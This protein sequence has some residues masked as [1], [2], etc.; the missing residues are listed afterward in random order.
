M[1]PHFWSQEL[2]IV[3]PFLMARGPFLPIQQPRSITPCRWPVETLA[4]PQLAIGKVG[5]S[6]RVEQ[7]TE[8]LPPL[9]PCHWEV[10][11]ILS[12]RELCGDQ[13]VCPS[14]ILGKGHGD[15]GLSKS[16]GRLQKD[17]SVAVLERSQSG[18]KGLPLIGPERLQREDSHELY[19][20]DG[21]GF[22]QVDKLYRRVGILFLKMKRDDSRFASQF[23]ALGT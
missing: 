5:L 8:I 9:R 20:W 11:H 17:V 15:R 10:F 7:R 23:A 2:H 16:R 3:T 13:D 4:A 6:C 22:S 12:L 18:Q 19:V 14:E 21:S 1:D